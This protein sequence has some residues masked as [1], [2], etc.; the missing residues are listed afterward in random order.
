M[1]IMNRLRLDTERL[2]NRVL[3]WTCLSKN[4]PEIGH[5][6]QKMVMKN[7]RCVYTILQMQFAL[8]GDHGGGQKLPPPTR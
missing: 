8:S 3:K 1:L 6:Y 7:K 2:L 4:E 5:A